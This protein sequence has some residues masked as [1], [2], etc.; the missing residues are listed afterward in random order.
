M[1]KGYKLHISRLGYIGDTGVMRTFKFPLVKALPPKKKKDFSNVPQELAEAIIHDDLYLRGIS[2]PVDYV[3]Y[4]INQ[5]RDIYSL[6]DLWFDSLKAGAIFFSNAKALRVFIARLYGN[7]NFTKL[8]PELTNY[9]EINEFLQK[10]VFRSP[11][12]RGGNKHEKLMK[13][14]TELSKM[15][16][17]ENPYINELVSVLLT[18]EGQIVSRDKQISYWKERWNL[19]VKDIVNKLSYDF[20]VFFHPKLAVDD[21]GKKRDILEIFEEIIKK[22]LLFILKH[23][24]LFEVSGGK[25]LEKSLLR[26]RDSSK[27][28][29]SDLFQLLWSCWLL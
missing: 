16:V 24:V 15:P 22:R 2:N 6:I 23:Y 17:D 9:F 26:L 19:D 8:L 27:I 10:I 13:L 5:G 7:D 21:L 1:E 20:T 28:S 29:L 3:K 11:D 25:V 4:V 12:L 18:K 14:L